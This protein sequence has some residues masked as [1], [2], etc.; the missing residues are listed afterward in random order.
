MTNEKSKAINRIQRAIE[1]AMEDGFTV[2]VASD[3]EGNNW[4]RIDPR[5]LNYDGT[6]DKYIALGVIAYVDE[7]EIF[8]EEEI[9]IETI[10]PLIKEYNKK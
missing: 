8:E 10:N 4:N 3:E 9:D 6:K 1:K 5:F 7:S 2:V